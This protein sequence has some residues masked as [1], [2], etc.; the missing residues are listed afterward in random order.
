M[1]SRNQYKALLTKTKQELRNYKIAHERL[2]AKLGEAAHQAALL[3][4]ELE[5]IRL[6]KWWQFWKFF[7]KNRLI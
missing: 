7:N 1:S 6:R 2:A 4:V 5:R 3:G